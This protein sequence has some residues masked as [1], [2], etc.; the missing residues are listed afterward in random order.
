MSIPTG[1]DD[2]GIA[3]AKVL[4]AYLADNGAFWATSGQVPG[5]IAVQQQSDVQAIESVAMAA[6]Q[7]NE[8]GRTSLAHKSFIEI[9]TA[10]ETA[11]G[12]ALA[13]ADADVA[14]E[15]KA[16]CEVIQAVLDRP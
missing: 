7:F 10:Y 13:S 4:M 2:D 9:Q 15:L 12:N 16:G 14:T 8:I 1:V 11:V 6:K 5:K 3:K